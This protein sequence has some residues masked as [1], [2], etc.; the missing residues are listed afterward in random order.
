MSQALEVAER[1]A[2]KNDFYLKNIRS[3]WRL[4]KFAARYARNPKAPRIARRYNE[5][6]RAQHAALESSLA[7][8][9]AR[10]A[11]LEAAIYESARPRPQRFRLIR[12]EREK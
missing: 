9:T 12:A 1:N 10:L 3:L 6:A 11:E 7:A 5:R 2:Q 4:R 8:N